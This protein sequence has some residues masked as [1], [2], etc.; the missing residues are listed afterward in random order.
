MGS[1]P[2]KLP[3]KKVKERIGLM[4]NSRFSSGF[5]VFFLRETSRRIAYPKTF[6]MDSSIIT[7]SLSGDLAHYQLSYRASEFLLFRLSVSSR[8][9]S[10]GV[11]LR[12]LT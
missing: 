6:F 7:K 10:G 3:S 8:S 12:S 5:L 1:T 9:R 11:D 2:P 4:R